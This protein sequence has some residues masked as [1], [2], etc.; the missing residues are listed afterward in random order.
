[1]I[2]YISD[3]H[4]GDE[5]VFLHC[6]RPFKDLREMEEELAKRWN[7]KVKEDDVVHLLGDLVDPS[8]PESLGTL[9]RFNGHK[10]LI[11]GNH[12]LP[13]LREIEGSGIFES[14]GYI[15]EIED[16][17]RKVCLSHYPMMDWMDY[18]YGSYLV[19]GHIHNKTESNGKEYGQMKEYHKDKRAYNAS[20]DVIGYEPRALDELI[21]L[22]EENEHEP[23]IN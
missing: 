16:E 6:R 9:K 8:C 2:Y 11:L 15:E 21:K 5:R 12:D 19:Y 7:A 14:I 17:G 22:K 1:M 13:L 23:Y 18:S 10:R 20:V 3:L 4:L